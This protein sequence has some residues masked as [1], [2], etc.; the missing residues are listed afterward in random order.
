MKKDLAALTVL[1]GKCFSNVV[2]HLTIDNFA[3]CGRVISEGFHNES[4]CQCM[5]IVPILNMLLFIWPCRCGITLK[6]GS[7]GKSDNPVEYFWKDGRPCWIELIASDNAIKTTLDEEDPGHV[8]L[9]RGWSGWWKLDGWAVTWIV[10]VGLMKEEEEDE[11][12]KEW[13]SRVDC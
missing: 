4:I 11:D 13:V 8:R 1:F 6:D 12:G 5:M 10:R 2:G 3:I 7:I 9:W